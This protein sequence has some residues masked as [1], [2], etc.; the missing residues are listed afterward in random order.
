MHTGR[1]L[2]SFICLN[3]SLERTRACRQCASRASVSSRVMG[4]WKMVCSICCSSGSGRTSSS[5]LAAR[6]TAGRP[7]RIEDSGITHKMPRRQ[8]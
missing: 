1:T 6:C 7:F 5:S 2:A 3:D 4:A 8:H